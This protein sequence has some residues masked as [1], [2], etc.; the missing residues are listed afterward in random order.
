MAPS[1]GLL[2]AVENLVAS[3]HGKFICVGTKIQPKKFFG[4]G[5]RSGAC[6]GRVGS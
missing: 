4:A 1:M 5:T 3:F 6:H 2:A